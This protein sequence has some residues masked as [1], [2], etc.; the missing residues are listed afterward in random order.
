MAGRYDISRFFFTKLVRFKTLTKTNIQG[1]YLERVLK[2]FTMEF[3]GGGVTS[4]LTGDLSLRGT[5]PSIAT[6]RGK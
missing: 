3:F 6:N 1:T 5:M 4:D 2:S